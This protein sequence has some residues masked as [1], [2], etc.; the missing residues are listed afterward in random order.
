MLARRA[1]VITPKAAYFDWLASTGTD[2]MWE[3]TDQRERDAWPLVFLVPLFTDEDDASLFFAEH[4]SAAFRS[5]LDFSPERRLWPKQ[6]DMEKFGEWFDVRP[7]EIVIDL[8]HGKFY[9]DGDDDFIGDDFHAWIEKMVEQGPPP[10]QEV[11]I[12]IVGDRYSPEA[13]ARLDSIVRL[14]RCF[15]WCSALSHATIQTT[16][17]S[18]GFDLT[19][20]TELVD[21]LH[22]HHNGTTLHWLSALAAVID[23][24]EAL[25][26]VDDEVTKYLEEGGDVTVEGSY[27]YRLER[28]RRAAFRFENDPALMEDA[29]DCC[30][31]EV[32]KWA[33]HLE[34]AFVPYFRRVLIKGGPAMRWVFG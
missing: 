27:R 30:Q 23:G 15:T 17:S 20:E 22:E 14:T 3:L 10:P 29:R 6:L 5:I 19:E 13:Q 34:S 8:S 9:I 18:M 28:A 32:V 16:V 24:W 1:V 2:G 26:L 31:G 4:V 11:T 21:D 25:H 33:S 7:G 12:S